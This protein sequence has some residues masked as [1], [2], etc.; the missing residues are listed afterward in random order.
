M[1]PNQHASDAVELQQRLEL[2]ERE[3]VTSQVNANE[4]RESHYGDNDRYNFDAGDVCRTWHPTNTEVHLVTFLILFQAGTSMTCLRIVREPETVDYKFISEHGRLRIEYDNPGTARRSTR[5]QRTNLQD[6]DDSES[7][8]LHLR[9]DQRM[10]DNCWIDMLNPWNINWQKEYRFAN[11]G[12]MEKESF[13]KLR[14]EH[15][16]LYTERASGSTS[17]N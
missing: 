4:P 17:G 5:R 7:Y 8:L 9:H 14:S 15:L 11:C 16:E 13:T 12:R 3:A 2:L 6:E 10:V 1:I